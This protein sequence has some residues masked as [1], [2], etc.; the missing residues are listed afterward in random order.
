MQLIAALVI[1]FVGLLSLVLLAWYR[2]CWKRLIA[3]GQNA[4]GRVEDIREKKY[5]KGLWQEIHVSYS[6][7]DTQRKYKTR[8]KGS[9]FCQ[10]Q[11]LTVRYLKDKPHFCVIDQ[12][13]NYEAMPEVFLTLMLFL[14]YLYLFMLLCI[15]FPEDRFDALRSM[16][17]DAG[18]LIAVFAW[19]LSERALIAQKTVCMGRIRCADDIGNERVILAEYTVNGHTYETREMRIPRKHC[20]K[21]YETGE[22]ITVKYDPKHPYRSIIAEDVYSFRAVKTVLLLLSLYMFF[23]AVLYAVDKI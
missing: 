7:N 21:A 10:H 18:M 13:R 3:E 1:A 12:T 20:K 16:V 17:L 22:E 15:L 19:Y 23:M 2:R 14:L 8:Q 9:R 4:L 11:Q 5:R 6:A